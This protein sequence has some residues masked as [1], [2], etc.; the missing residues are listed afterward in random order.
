MP[1]PAAVGPPLGRTRTMVTSQLTLS[2]RRTVDS[3]AMTFASADMLL[4]SRGRLLSVSLQQKSRYMG[5][6]LDTLPSACHVNCHR[7]CTAAAR[8]ATP[9][10][11]CFCVEYRL[12]RD[13]IIVCTGPH[14]VMS[15]ALTTTGA[16]EQGSNVVHRHSGRRPWRTET[17]CEAGCTWRRNTH[18]L[19][20]RRPPLRR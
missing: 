3:S 7:R 5:F 15:C 1:L 6:A 20:G 14:C 17:A 8:A 16:G 19:C 4:D 13:G 18:P 10:G 9:D 12:Q 2:L 11:I